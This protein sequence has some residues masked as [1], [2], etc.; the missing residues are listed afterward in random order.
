MGKPDSASGYEKE[1]TENCERLLVTLLRGLGPWKNSIYLVGGLTPRYLV[2]MLP[3]GK[4]P[5]AG[6][7]DVDIVVELQML[8]ETDAYHTL[9]DNLKKMGFER[10]VNE[11]GEKQ[12]WRW[13]TKTEKGVPIIL[14]LLADNPEVS[15][16]KVKP[17]PTHGKI[18]ALNIP[19]S[20]IVF[21]EYEVKEIRAEL[22][23]E[24][25]IAVE[26]VRHANLVS[27][28]CLKA[29]ALDHRNERKDAHDLVFCIET[30]ERG[31][32]RGCQI[33]S[34]YPAGQAWRGR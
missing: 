20:S 29:F 10:A 9:E 19:H 31:V 22:L 25:G 32:G 28:T 6:T 15:G 11:K 34:I 4:T 7:G 21:D 27:F 12:S 17:L 23:G 18:S 16:G 33:V 8:A 13:A 2:P 14:E 3:P 26:A 30:L 24:N 1:V 5:H